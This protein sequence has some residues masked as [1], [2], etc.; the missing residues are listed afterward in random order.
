MRPAHVGQLPARTKR[1]LATSHFGCLGADAAAEPRAAQAR[2]FGRALGPTRPADARAAA[3]ASAALPLE[4]PRES[5]CRGPWP[6]ASRPAP[7]SAS[8]ATDTR[9]CRCEFRGRLKRPKGWQNRANR[10]AP[11]AVRGHLLSGMHRLPEAW[12]QKAG[13]A[14]ARVG[15]KAIPGTWA[16]HVRHLARPGPGSQ[17]FSS[18]G[19]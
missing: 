6:C 4:Q 8:D 9:S 11:D 7:G 1:R 3:W 13:C 2:R 14:G 12:R 15:G 19:W 18:Q 5:C 10:P 17:F 16:Q